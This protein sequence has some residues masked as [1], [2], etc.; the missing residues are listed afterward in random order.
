MAVPCNPLTYH[1]VHDEVAENRYM[2]VEGD[3]EGYI[4]KYSKPGGHNGNL[5]FSDSDL[6]ICICS[7]RLRRDRPSLVM[8]VRGYIGKRIHTLRLL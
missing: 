2:N 8:K 3:G 6:D 5:V 1:V 7:S 4:I